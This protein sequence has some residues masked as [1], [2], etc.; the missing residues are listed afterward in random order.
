MY[1]TARESTSSH[2]HLRLNERIL[3]NSASLEPSEHIFIDE[4]DLRTYSKPE[5][6]ICSSRNILVCKIDR[7][8]F[9]VL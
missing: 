9:I 1:W 7:F 5:K 8:S 6:L 4:Q 3:I 2:K